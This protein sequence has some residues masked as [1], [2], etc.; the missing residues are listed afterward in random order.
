ML[1][2]TFSNFISGTSIYIHTDCQLCSTQQGVCS[3]I[4]YNN[5]CRTHLNPTAHNNT[6]YTNN[7]EP[8]SSEACT[9]LIPTSL[10]Q[11]S[12]LVF[13]LQVDLGSS[14][15]AKTRFFFL[16][17]LWHRF[18]NIYVHMDPLKTTVVFWTGP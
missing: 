8:T 6:C 10:N 18:K 15:L 1:K 4:H 2:S 7:L 5:K 16:C 14:R 17:L 11:T 9:C 13:P 12:Q 3:K